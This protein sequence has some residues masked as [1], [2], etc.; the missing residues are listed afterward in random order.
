MTNLTVKNVAAAVKGSLMR[1]Q[2]YQSNK[3]PVLRTDNGP[4]LIADA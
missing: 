2:L 1:H 4:Q 3:K